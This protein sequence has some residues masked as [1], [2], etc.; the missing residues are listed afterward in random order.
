VKNLK[1]NDDDLQDKSNDPR[2]KV[3]TVDQFLV[4]QESK[5]QKLLEDELVI[6]KGEF[7]CIGTSKNKMIFSTAIKF[8][9]KFTKNVTK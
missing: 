9:K 7:A 8:Y 2:E 5:Q 6:G 4:Q 1:I 3:V